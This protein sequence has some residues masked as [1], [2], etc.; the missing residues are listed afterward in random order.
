MNPVPPSPEDWAAPQQRALESADERRNRPDRRR[1]FWWS[2]LY[3]SVRPR[4]RS[5]A[6]RTDDGRFHATDWHAPHLWAAS[7]GILLLNVADAF[8]TEL[9]MSAGAVEVN[10]FMAM[11]VGG[12]NSIA[13]F[14]A[15][16]MAITSVCV[17]LMV[18]LARYRFMRVLRVDVIMYGLLVAYS[19]LAIHELRMIHQFTD[20]HLL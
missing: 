8:M 9:L 5:P 14:A 20:Q 7:V 6:R 1:R 15:L 10:P 17:I 18:Y 3:G 13:V 2:L 19:I 11:F 4:R 12:N 16:K